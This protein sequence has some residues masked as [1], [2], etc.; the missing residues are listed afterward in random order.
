M[1]QFD[2]KLSKWVETTNYRYKSNVVKRYVKLILMM[3]SWLTPKQVL[4]LRL[5]GWIVVPG[6]LKKSGRRLP[7][8]GYP[9]QPLFDKDT[10]G[11]IIATSHDL[12]PNGRVVGEPCLKW[13]YFREIQVGKIL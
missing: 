2:Q 10:S 12:T 11:Q 5:R 3:I 6:S 8:E 4:P 7:H 9:P 13:P 1:I